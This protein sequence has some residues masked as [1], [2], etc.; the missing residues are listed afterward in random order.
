MNTKQLV[1]SSIIAASFAAVAISSQAA[2]PSS[3]AGEAYHAFVMPGATSDTSRAMVQAGVL[4]ARARGEL[5][6][7]QATPR[8]P[9]DGVST[10]ART[11]VREAVPDARRH[12]DLVAQGELIAPAT[13]QHSTRPA[14]FARNTRR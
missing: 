2:G 6:A 4:Q 13:A 14:L 8:Q 9:Y 7:G 10:L 12:G 11:D 1:V 3:Q 5:F